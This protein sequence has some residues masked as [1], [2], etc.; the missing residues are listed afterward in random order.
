MDEKEKPNRQ[1]D[2]GSVENGLPLN[3]LRKEGKRMKSIGTLKI[4]SAQEIKQSRV[5]IGFE[6]YDRDL[7]D[8]EKCYDRVAESGAKFARCQT[9]WARTEKTK[10][11]YDFAWLDA[12][13]DN[14]S[15]R[16]VQPWFNVGY[17]NPI[18]M[19]DAP[20][21]T[22]VGCVPTLYGEEVVAAWCRYVK[23]LCEH[24]GDR[25]T[26]Y[27]IW[28][29]PDLSHFWY[30]E[31]PSGEKFGQFYK[32]TAEVI[33]SVLPEAKLGFCTSESKGDYLKEIF[34]QLKACD[35]DF[36]CVHNYDRKLEFGSRFVGSYSGYDFVNE[37]LERY[38]F[39][40]VEMWMGEGGHASWHPVG[41]GQCRLGGG[42][43]H[44]QAVWI[45]R[46]VF[47]DF[48]KGLR[49]SS[50][51]M[52]VDLW[53][54]PYEMAVEVQKKPAAQ[55]LL[56]GVSYEPKQGY[57]AF[58]RLATVL[59]G[60]TLPVLSEL[61]V[62]LSTPIKNADPSPVTVCY[63][64]DGK[65]FYAYWVPYAIEDERGVTGTATLSF[66]G[67]SRIKDP[68]VVDLLSGEVWEPSEGEWDPQKR[69]ISNLPIGE[70][71]FVVC[72]RG[73]VGIN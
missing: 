64:V 63:T 40:H 45:L 37:L 24:F 7:F 20:N 9:G 32:L 13:V 28:N 55:G 52:V 66:D 43:E 10:G 50:I 19:H 70:W 48:R 42:S 15:K 71:P 51:F 38:G 46:R 72:E 25:V 4:K 68:V 54:K 30:S 2:I 36:L 34:A 49:L 23:A 14:L 65:E 44:R 61:S 47:G 35:L 1:Y 67:D 26:H 73:G 29:E 22:A 41:H 53:Q 16:G 3:L 18:Y 31:K 17:G 57:Y 12:V 8:P 6:C 56:R 59:G 69:V 33:R 27:E 58:S 62:A 60:D 5:S 11:E 21:S 39:T